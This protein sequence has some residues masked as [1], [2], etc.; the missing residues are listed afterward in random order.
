MLTAS[1]PLSTAKEGSEQK[2]REQDTVRE[3]QK[4]KPKKRGSQEARLGPDA[5]K[6][7][8]GVGVRVGGRGLQVQILETSTPWGWDWS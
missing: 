7:G 5:E 1:R 6:E 3:T 8:V 4:T 2:R